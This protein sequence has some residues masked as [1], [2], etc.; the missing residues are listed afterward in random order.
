VLGVIAR[1]IEKKASKHYRPRPN[2]LVYVNL[3]ELGNEWTKL[4]AFQFAHQWSGH[5]ASCWL[6]WQDL[7]IRLWPNPCRI[8]DQRRA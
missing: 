2:L 3:S 1:A 8:R 5:F 6:L 4:S 7:I